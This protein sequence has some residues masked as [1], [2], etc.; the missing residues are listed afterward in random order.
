MQA[1]IDLGIPTYLTFKMG[2]TPHTGGVFFRVWAPHANSVFVMGDFN[3][4]KPFDISMLPQEGGE[5]AINVEQAKAGD[6]YKYVIKNGDLELHRNDP[7]ARALTHSAGKSI[8]YDPNFDWGDDDFIM[9]DHNDL[10]LYELHIGTF[11]RTQPNV[12]GTFFTAIQRLD[13][14]QWLGVNA[15]EI[16][17]PFEFSGALSW[18]YNPSQ[19]FAIESTY[20]GPNAFKTFV[21]E[22]HK[23]RIAVILDVVYNHFGPFDLDLWQFDGWSEDGKGGIYF[24][25][26]WRSQ[27]PWG[28]TRPDYGRPEVRRYLTDNALMWLSEYRCDG[29]RMDMVP[30]MRNVHANGN[31]ADNLD[32]GYTT[33]REINRA[34]H[35]QFPHKIVIAEDMHTLSDITADLRDGGLGYSAQWDAQFVHPMQEVLKAADDNQRDMLKVEKAFLFRYNNDAFSRV[36]YTESHDE[37]ANGKARIVEDIAPGQDGDNV[38]AERRSKLGI[39][40]V[41]TA[42]GIPMLFQGQAILESGWFSDTDAIDWSKLKENK[43]FAQSIRD[44]VRLRRD[45]AGHTAGLKSQHTETLHLDNVQKVIAFHRFDGPATEPQHSVVVV[46]NF[47]NQDQDHYQIH[48][49]DSGDWTLVY[50][51]DVEH[52]LKPDK[53]DAKA[54]HLTA[55]PGEHGPTGEVHL[56]PYGF[57]IYAKTT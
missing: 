57:L 35:S 17:P 47:R 34:V 44:L 28:D 40:L 53:A 2:A 4:W 45:F 43:G 49:P 36:I 8:V 6:E 39:G 54:L 14:L 15:V 1:P 18:G 7:Y 56:S 55:I 37:V 25:N 12:P 42:P 5:W 31:P 24:Y 52:L 33:I 23:R 41:M 46:A 26:D 50:N 29:L 51:S 11:Q 19:P 30:Y 22:A 3:D 38:F 32:S 20:G 10:I 27:T 16:M 9:P 48:F 21:K 13:Y